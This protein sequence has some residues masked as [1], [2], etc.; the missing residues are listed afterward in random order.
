MDTALV[1]TRAIHFG[2]SMLVFGEL[3]FV[4]FVAG[5]AWRRA[6]AASTRT[7]GLDRHAFVFAIAALAA[8]ALSGI[9]WVVLEAMQMAGVPITQAVANGTVVVVLEKTEF[10]HVFELRALLWLALAASLVALRANPSSRSR[11]GVALCVGG[12]YLATLAAAGHAAA[13]NDG[14]VRAMHVAADA[15]HLLAAGGWLGALPP[16]V[17]CLMHA[18]SAQAAAR[19]ARRFSLLGIVCVAT[20]IASGIVNSLFLVGSFA[21]LFGTAYGQLLVIKLALFAVM[22]AIAATNRFHLTPRLASDD[23]SRRSLARNARLELAGGIAIVAIVG[24]LGT[25]VPGAHRSPR[26]PFEF[27]LDF[28][29]GDLSAAALAL[30]IAC[31]VLALAAVALII[32]GMRRSAVRMSIPGCVA[33]LVLAAVSTSIF[34]VPAFPTT[35]ATSPVPY[36]VDTVSHGAQGFAKDC[37]GCHGADARG[38]GPLAATLPRK[39][40]NLAEHALHHPEGNL[41]WWIAHGI[42]ETPMP[43]FSPRI[44]DD[45]IWKIV[46]YLV[47]RAS[48]EAATSI[49]PR[50]D[51]ASMSRAPDFGYEIAGEGQRTLAGERTPALIVL[52]TLPQSDARL[53]QLASDHRLVHGKLRVIAIPLPASRPL[54]ADA[55]LQAQVGPDVSSVYAM[56]AGARGGPAPAHAELLVDAN[57]IVRARWIGVPTNGAGRDA[58]IVAAAQHLPARSSMPASMHHGH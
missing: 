47:A 53:S 52:Y 56:F 46:Q 40:A 57:G 38:D 18:P 45:G 50:V 3:A 9:A 39:P 7:S 36:T 30:L 31:A 42:A 17:H 51:T 27:A 15:L 55:T 13:A 43:A 11:I 32:S 6:A 58:E 44:S 8:S 1:A 5:S 4:A 20:L 54:A 29:L 24:A 35:F 33:L 19:V 48:A 14:G 49:G 37:S 12:A 26:W 23:A 2:A 28:T 41:F 21:A 22:L 16:L 25:M 10:G 34:A